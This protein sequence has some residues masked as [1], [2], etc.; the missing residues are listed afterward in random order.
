MSL[1]TTSE[2]FLRHSDQVDTVSSIENMSEEMNQGFR[3]MKL[4]K[5]L[6]YCVTVE[7]FCATCPF[8]H[9]H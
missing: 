8:L 2:Q 6:F 3:Q 4:L 1:S 7:L 9:L 5:L